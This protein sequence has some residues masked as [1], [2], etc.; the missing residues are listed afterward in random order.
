MKDFKLLQE[1]TSFFTP[2]GKQIESSNDENLSEI[3]LCIDT[4]DKK[5]CAV[6]LLN[7]KFDFMMVIQKTSNASEKDLKDFYIN[8][9]IELEKQILTFLQDL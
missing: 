7:S 4:G 5:D 2:N 3:H 9:R 6:L 1:E 8:N